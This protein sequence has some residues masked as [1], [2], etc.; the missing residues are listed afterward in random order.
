MVS[1]SENYPRSKVK[2]G[3][4]WSREGGEGGRD[5]F[6]LVVQGYGIQPTPLLRKVKFKVARWEATFCNIM[7][8]SNFYFNILLK[9]NYVIVINYV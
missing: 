1:H 7:F 4:I 9:I 2:K 8:L 5:P 6:L 3:T